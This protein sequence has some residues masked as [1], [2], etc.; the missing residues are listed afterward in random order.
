MAAQC[1]GMKTHTRQPMPFW[2]RIVEATLRH[3]LPFIRRMRKYCP[4]TA[5]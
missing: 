3:A 4:G 5:R 2:R 1:T